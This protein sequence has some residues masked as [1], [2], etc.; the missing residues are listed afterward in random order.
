MRVGVLL[1]VAELEEDDR[2]VVLAAAAVRR[3]DER[4]RRGFRSSRLRST[5]ARIVVVVDHRREPVGAEHEEVARATL[6]L[7]GVDV[8][9]GVGAERARDHRALRVR[10]GLLRRELAAADELGDERVVLGQLL[11]LAVADEVRARVADVAD[12]DACPS[13]TSA[14]VIVVPIP[15]AEASLVCRS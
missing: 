3:A 4:L 7:E 1:L 11:E 9:V 13:S 6:D 10:L 2:D 15:E 14:T 12:P 5:S 8:D